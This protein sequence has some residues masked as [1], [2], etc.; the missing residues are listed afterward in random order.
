M[1]QLQLAFHAWGDAMRRGPPR[2]R[3]PHAAA[4]GRLSPSGRRR[5]FTPGWPASRRPFQHS[6]GIT[7]LAG[8]RSRDSLSRWSPWLAVRL[9]P[10]LGARSPARSAGLR[11]HMRLVLVLAASNHYAP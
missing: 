3:R 7:G 10:A 4:R 8:G 5:D 11:L 6:G 2:A 1:G 9:T